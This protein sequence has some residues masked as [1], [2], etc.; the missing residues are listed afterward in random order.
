MKKISKK[1]SLKKKTVAVLSKEQ[2]RQVI[3]GATPTCT[4][5]PYCNVASIDYMKKSCF[6]NYT[7]ID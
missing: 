3:G 6:C 5:S 4:Q 1:L 2:T 7:D